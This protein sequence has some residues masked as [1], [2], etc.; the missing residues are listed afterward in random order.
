VPL[1]QVLSD[2]VL[3]GFGGIADRLIGFLLLPIT[4][5]ILGSA[6]FGVYNL[7][8]TT[9]AILFLLC[10]L[11]IQS[12]YFR[13]A[14]DA[15]VRGGAGRVLNV[16]V[17]IVH[18]VSL[19]WIPV[20]LFFAGPLADSL[21]GV[22]EPWFVYLLCLRTYSDVVGSL[23][24]CKLQA[25]GRI[26]LFLCLRIPLTV[27][28]RTVSLLA[29]IEYRTP[30]A[31]AAGEALAAT[32]GVIPM[33]L[34]VL[35][36]VRLQWDRTVAAMMIQY[37][38]AT[39]PGV[40]AAWA[41][42]AANRYLL[43]GLGPNG[44]EDVGLFSLAERF[45]SVM[46]LAGQTMWLGWRRFAFRN[47]HLAE[48]PELLA[49]GFTLYYCISAFVL[50][51]IAILGP[52]ATHL[53][54]DPAFGP[55]AR[56]IAPLTLSAFFGT[57]ALPLRMGLIKENRT[58]TMSGITIVLA[59]ITLGLALAWIPAYASAGA[60]AASLVGQV[61]GLA[62]TWRL[63]Q[64]VFHVPIETRRLGWLTVWFGGFYSV[65]AL[66]EPLGWGVVLSGGSDLL[67]SL[68]C[69]L[70]RFCP[71]S[72]EERAQIGAAVRPALRRLGLGA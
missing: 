19:V 22:G 28:V 30:L 63:S 23:A 51:G 59:A 47:M 24:D 32:A 65:G 33:V 45:G 46:L 13:F 10:S 14:T 21:I 68:Q 34:Y 69:A 18:A 8:A 56:L 48:G 66:L 27:L 57:I 54:I 7:Y 38:A 43:K 4:A 6:G 36:D 52:A 61:V 62:A 31:L 29:L 55:A 20:A 11:G 58:M 2:S 44:I 64:R 67:L 72:E 3:F 17:T 16:A 25:D 42:V 53:L 50:F 39:V 70:Y 37:G 49:R 15:S 71:L 60:V 26:K 12:A 1:R 5:S 41:L 9:S 35:R 40:I